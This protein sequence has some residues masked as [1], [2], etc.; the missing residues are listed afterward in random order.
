MKNKVIGT[1]LAVGA[2][3]AHA[4]DFKAYPTC[5]GDGSLAMLERQIKAGD[6]LSDIDTDAIG[7]KVYDL[8]R[9]RHF[10]EKD[11][12]LPWSLRDAQTVAMDQHNE[13]MRADINRQQRERFEREA[14]E[15]EENAPKLKA[16]GEAANALYRECL[17]GNARLLALNSNEPAEIVTRATFASCRA[18]RAVIADVHARYKDR[19]FGEESLVMADKLLTGKVLLEVIQERALPRNTPDGGG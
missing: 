1:M 9:A 19:W 12:P 15:L 6:R 10:G 2:S 17:Y 18:E 8:C 16:E 14:K 5:V 11:P 7:K 13:L 3:V 4:Q